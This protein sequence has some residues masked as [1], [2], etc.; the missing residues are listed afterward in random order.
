MARQLSSTAVEAQKIRAALKQEFPGVKFSVRTDNYSLGSSIHI[1]WTDFPTESAVKAI[2]GKYEEVSRDERTGEVL[3]GGNMYVFC[4]NTWTKET[5]ETIQARMPENVNKDDRYWF[6][7]TAEEMWEEMLREPQPEILHLTH[8]CAVCGSTDVQESGNDGGMGWCGPCGMKQEI[9]PLTNPAPVDGV[10]VTLNKEKSGIEITFA[11]KPA[12][13]IIAMLKEN[14]FRWSK[15]GFWYAKQTPERLTLAKALQEVPPEPAEVEAAVC[16]EVEPAK[17]ETIHVVNDGGRTEFQVPASDITIQGEYGPRI[18]DEKVQAVVLERYPEGG[19]GYTVQRGQ[20]NDYDYLPV[21]TPQKFPAGEKV[22][23]LHILFRWSESGAIRG[24]E[25]FTTWAEANRL[26]K[27]A[28]A[29]HEG[30]YGA[31]GGYYKTSFVVGFADGHTY[32]GRLDINEKDDDITGHIRDFAEFSAGLR[33][34]A[35][36]S[37]EQYDNYV[38][39]GD[40]Q[41]WQEFLDRYMLEDPAPT[42][43]E[44]TKRANVVQFP[45]AKP[46]EKTMAPDLSPE[47]WLKLEMVKQVL[48]ADNAELG[49]QAGMS[50]DTMFSML[51]TA[52]MGDKPQV[53]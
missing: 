48:G 6:I 5:R 18:I 2:A 8:K 12:A 11:E 40:A 52:L 50:P 37:Q 53:H 3:S 32:T 21:T 19:L 4:D 38:R 42:T 44:P 30:E 51:A 46:Q 23:M 16:E 22:P 49:I 47:Q 45:G 36:M 39:G 1:S 41:S 20:Y 25:K 43:P 7:K 9:V 31:G 35:H 34:P 26:V 17:M 24:G 29:E 10:T 33:K 14:G 15:R 27:R 28:A 13:G